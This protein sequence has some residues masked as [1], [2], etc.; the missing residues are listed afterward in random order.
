TPVAGSVNRLWLFDASVPTAAPDGANT[1]NTT[2]PLLGEVANPPV[3]ARA[4]EMIC[5]A[6]P[7][8]EYR[9]TSPGAEIVPD[10]SEPQPSTDESCG[11]TVMVTVSA[12]LSSCPSLTIS[13][14]T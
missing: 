4:S 2:L 7:V 1:L 5:P 8:N 12:A 11:L 10:T 6:W 9:S 13:C 14:T 3:L